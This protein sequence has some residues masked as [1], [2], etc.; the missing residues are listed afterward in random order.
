MSQ[1][2]RFTPHGLVDCLYSDIIDLRTLG[3]LQVVRATDI[4]FNDS[5]QE[6]DVHDADNGTVLFSHTA[7]SECL[8]WEQTNLQPGITH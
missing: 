4:C 7:R 1:T 6:W 2:L 3:R 5:S 8:Y